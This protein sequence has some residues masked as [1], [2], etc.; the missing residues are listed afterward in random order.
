[1]VRWL[2]AIML[3]GA[4]RIDEL[5]VTGKPCPCPSGWVCDP[6]TETCQRSAPPG[7]DASID[8]ML[9][10]AGFDLVTG[11]R[12]HYRFDETAGQQVADS[13]PTTRRGFACSAAQTTWVPGKVGNAMRFNGVGY[14]SYVMFPHG[15]GGS[16]TCAPHEAWTGSFTVSMWVQF[17]SFH[18]YNGY[19]LGDYAASYGSAGGNGGAWG[20]GA[21]DE[22]TGVTV[23]G[24]SVTTPTN[25]RVN[26]CGTTPLNVASWY[27]LTGVYDQTARTLDIYVNGVKDSGAL[28]SN[29]PAV[30]A[31]LNQIPQDQ[32]PYIASSA[33]QNSLLF[34]SVD[35]F[36]LYERALT[37]AEIAELYRISQ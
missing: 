16:C 14:M 1:M 24:V 37:A 30:P 35:E 36:R 13:S 10:D 27:F 26:R 6:G 33:N 15:G 8:A 19:T 34:G 23:A 28:T 18:G 21:L 5:D 12:Y 7:E 3:I 17:D 31:S 9:T 32:C 4:C 29:S 2:V 20:L 11:L 25:G 22:C